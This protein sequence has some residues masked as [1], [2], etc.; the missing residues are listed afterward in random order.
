MRSQTFDLSWDSDP[1]AFIT[2]DQI[3]YKSIGMDLHFHLKQ[4][5]SAL[6]TWQKVETS[7]SLVEAIFSNQLPGMVTINSK[8]EIELTHS[9]RFVTGLSQMQGIQGN[10]LNDKAVS[11]D[12][13]DPQFTSPIKIR[14]DK[15]NSL[16][17]S[18]QA[19]EYFWA[20]E[21]SEF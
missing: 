17:Q 4:T 2:W 1:H 6:R 9:I 7:D 11:L 5:A 10:K 3:Y 20:P 12:L 18:V 16:F 8:G 13:V 19:D 14:T 15:L 21:T